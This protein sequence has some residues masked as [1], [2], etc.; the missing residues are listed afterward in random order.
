M[1]KKNNPEYWFKETADCKIETGKVNEQNI[2]S[3]FKVTN[4]VASAFAHFFQMDRTGS[5]D[6]LR[7]RKGGTIFSGGGS[8]QVKHGLDMTPTSKGGKEQFGVYIDS[9]NG[10]ML[11]KCGGRLTIQAANISMLAKD[12][13]G[14]IMIEAKDKV[15]IK[16]TTV[17]TTSIMD[18]TFFSQMRLWTI[19]DSAINM[20][21]GHVEAVDS[22]SFIKGSDPV[23]TKEEIKA[24]KLA[25][26]LL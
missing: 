4:N 2:V 16:G 26:G 9:G 19:G 12:G 3:G 18:T 25:S 10:D 15:N 1:A 13:E 6:D 23:D 14:N 20:I 8:F 11:I 7:F 22:G 24:R 17:T 5:G 21:A